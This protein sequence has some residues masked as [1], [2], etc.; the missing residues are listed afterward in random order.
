MQVIQSL[1][2]LGSY[3]ISFFPCSPPQPGSEG[4]SGAQ[5]HGKKQTLFTG[6]SP[7]CQRPPPGEGGGES[8]VLQQTPKRETGENQP[9]PQLLSDQDQPKLPPTDE[10]NTEAHGLRASQFIKNKTES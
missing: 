3:L 10:Q 5:L 2:S 4:G 7:H 9:Q 6:N 8:V 1:L